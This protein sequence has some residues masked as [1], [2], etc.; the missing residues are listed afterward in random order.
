M[1]VCLH[2]TYTSL[3]V[4]MIT[5]L[6]SHKSKL[7]EIFHTTLP[8]AVAQFSSDKNAIRYVLPVSRFCGWCHVYT[9]WHISHL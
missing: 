9:M 2:I 5:H 4:C 7:H 8:P 3:H 1:S 6:T